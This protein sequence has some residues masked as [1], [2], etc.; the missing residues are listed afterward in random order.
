MKV[1]IKEGALVIHDFLYCQWPDCKP[2]RSEFSDGLP[3]QD[4][5]LY[6]NAVFEGEWLDRDALFDDEGMDR[7][8]RRGYWNCIRPGYGEIGQYGNGSIFVYDFNSVE[9]VFDDASSP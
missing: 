8:E 2:P 5:T 7:E 1:K 3:Y 6:P 4:R 9:Q